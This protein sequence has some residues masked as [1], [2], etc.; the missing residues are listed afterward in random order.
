MCNKAID[1]YP[2]ALELFP[3]C[4]KSQKIRNKAVNTYS[5]AIKFVSE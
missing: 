5:F 2:H 3:D 1:D 4:L